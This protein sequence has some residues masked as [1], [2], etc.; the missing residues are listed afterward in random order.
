VQFI[1]EKSRAAR[2]SAGEKIRDLIEIVLRSSRKLNI[3]AH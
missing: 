3:Q 1:K 2:P